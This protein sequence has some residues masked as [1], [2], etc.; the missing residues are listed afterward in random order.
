MSGTGARRKPYRSAGQALAILD[1]LRSHSSKREARALERILKLGPTFVPTL[2]HTAAHH[3]N[4]FARDVAVRAIARLHPR[5]RPVLLR[6]LRDPAMAIRLHA[7]VELDRT[8]TAQRP[9]R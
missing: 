1:G 7:L 4:A 2:I 3:P 9:A 6:A 8:W 5:P